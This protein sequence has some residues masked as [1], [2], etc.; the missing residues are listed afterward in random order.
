[1]YTFKT[2]P[3]LIS[4]ALLVASVFTTSVWAQTSAAPASREEVKTDGK[5]AKAAGQTPK[6][7]AGLRSD[8]KGGV[9]A[10]TPTAKGSVTTREE[11]RAQARAANKGGDIAKG[12]AGQTEN[13]AKRAGKT[14]NT[15]QKSRA[16]VRSG[17]GMTDPQI[18]KGE[19]SAP[20]KPVSPK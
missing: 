17:A 2:N 9:T 12:E 1:M 4:G 8:G 3:K 10:G 16:E 13:Q 18:P 20:M 14:R 7:E 19:G 6:G 15:S 11:V 5:D